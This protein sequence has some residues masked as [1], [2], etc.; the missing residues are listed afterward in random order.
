MELKSKT[1]FV[2]AENIHL[3]KAPILSENL[4]FGLNSPMLIYYLLRS[5]LELPTYTHMISLD[6]TVSAIASND[7]Q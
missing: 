5:M 4:P 2:Y 1:T 3:T 6:L 7:A